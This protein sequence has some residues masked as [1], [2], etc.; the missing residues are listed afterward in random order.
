MGLHFL[1]FWPAHPEGE[2]K[3]CLAG[4]GSGSWPQKTP[5]GLGMLSAQV[6]S[7]GGAS[8]C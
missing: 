3:D 1:R 6:D 4:P 7:P 5:Q 8:P 2:R